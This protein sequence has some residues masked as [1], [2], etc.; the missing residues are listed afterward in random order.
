M[1]MH[2]WFLCVQRR[3]KQLRNQKGF[4]AGQSQALDTTEGTQQSRETRLWFF[5]MA[6]S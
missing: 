3:K 6:L 1:L 2:C 5:T 4:W